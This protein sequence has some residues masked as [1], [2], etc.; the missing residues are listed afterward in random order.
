V[1]QP[2]LAASPAAPLVGWAVIAR[3][4]PAYPVA[5]RRRGAEGEVLLRAE[6]GAAGAPLGITVLRSSGHPDLDAAA[7]AAVEKWRFRAAGPFAVEVPLVF[8]LD[9]RAP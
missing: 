2:E 9:G 8:R 4:P 7:V 3:A 1:R 5:A 6:I